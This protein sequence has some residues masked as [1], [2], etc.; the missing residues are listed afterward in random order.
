ME[1]RLSAL[2]NSFQEF[3]SVLDSI[4]KKLED[5]SNSSVPSINTVTPSQPS[6][7]TRPIPVTLSQPEDNTALPP[8]PGASGIQHSPSEDVQ[9]T[10]A[11][12]KASVQH[13]RLPAELTLSSSGASGLKKGEAQAHTIINKIA[14]ITETI[15]KVLKTKDDPYDDTF[16]CLVALINILQDEQA[17]LLVQSSFD[18]TVAKFFRNLRRGG[19]FT[20]DAIEDLRS[21]ASI[22]A[23]YRPQQQQQP[24]SAGRG[25]PFQFQPQRDFFSRSSGRGFP[26]QRGGRRG[27][28]QQ[29]ERD[30]Q[31]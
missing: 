4:Q 12:I 31:D 13:V 28:Q 18:P 24:R 3:R 30:N 10:Y 23:A 5:N 15:F 16:S 1:D 21:A 11:S 29:P 6:I 22:A 27:F 7:N 25:Q 20:P 17:A 26:S 19:G 8:L 2:E 14:R 9:A